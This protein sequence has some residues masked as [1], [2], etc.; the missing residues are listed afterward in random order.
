[1]NSNQFIEKRDFSHILILLTI[2]LGIGIYLIFT[3]VQ[4]SKDGVVYIE[5]AQAFSSN[6]IEMIKSNAY[7]FGYPFLIFVSHK[8][9]M[10]FSDQST[11]YTW[12]YSAQFVTLICRLIALILLYFI[13][14]FFIG[15]SDGRWP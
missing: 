3:T 9:A 4:I 1:M 12:L 11:V 2:A 15:S 5:R 6:P 13:G 14:K 10:L 8:I 7:P